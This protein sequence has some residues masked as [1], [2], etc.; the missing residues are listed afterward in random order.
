MPHINRRQLLIATGLG[1]AGLFL[2]SIRPTGSHAQRPQA[3]PIKRL[4]IMVSEH[5]TV[6]DSWFMRRGN[7]AYGNW[8]YALDDPNPRSFSKILRPLH[9][10]RDKLLIL[11]GLSQASTLGDAAINGHSA[12]H[13]HL[14]TGARFISELE[15]GGPS[16]DQIVARAVSRPDRIRSLELGSGLPSM[17]GYV[18]A[19]PRRRIRPEL[20]PRRAF[21]R[22]FPNAS[23]EGERPTERALVSSARRSVLDF[24]KNEYTS[25]SPRLGR[26]DRLLLDTHRGLVRELEQ[27]VE[28]LTQLSCEA[29]A[30]PEIPNSLDTVDT[31]KV[32]A[33]MIVA[34]FACD[35]TRVATL[36]AGELRHHEFGAPPVDIHQDVAHQTDRDPKAAALMTKFNARYAEIFAHIL[37]RLALYP[38]GD[39]TLLDNT[40]VVWLTE[41]ATGPHELARIPVVMA[42]SA[43]GYFRTGRYLSYENDLPNPFQFLG[44]PEGQ[45]AIGPG[46]S[47]LLISLMQAMGMPNDQIGAT[48]VVTRDGIANVIDLTGPLP[49]LT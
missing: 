49:R 46:H 34:A 23:L 45:G 10:H 13:L 47:H 29:T 22:L 31:T 43:G 17:G 4:L 36:Q 28:A 37:D 8:E 18:N 25:M 20:Q 19:G 3:G 7:S 14:L 44:W 15:A 33:D 16:V 24:V 41:L 9:A 40:V 21:D 39:R 27:R 35:L 12:A 26:E 5:G 48:S 1:G 32:M 11:E 30:R 6:R 42:G 38:D 2:P